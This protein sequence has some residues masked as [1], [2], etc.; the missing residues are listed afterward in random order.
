MD[1]TE[2]PTEKTEALF[3][4][5]TLRRRPMKAHHSGSVYRSAYLTQ[6]DIEGMLAINAHLSCLSHSC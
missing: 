5:S 1:C 4:I 3:A 6:T 2:R